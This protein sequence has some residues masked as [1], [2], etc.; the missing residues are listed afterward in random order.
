MFESIV[1]HRW[2]EASFH[3]HGF[4]KNLS[5][6]PYQYKLIRGIDFYEYC[7]NII[8]HQPNV[9]ISFGQVSQMRSNDEGTFLELNGETI[10]AGYIFNSILFK[11]TVVGADEYYLSQHFKGIIIETASPV[12]DPERATLMDFR[13]DQR[14]GT[15]FVYIMPF[16]PKRAL[17][18]YTL[19]SRE[20]LPT[21][22][23]DKGL[24]EYIRDYLKPGSYQITG[25]E[26]GVIPMTNYK[27]PLSDGKIINIGTAGGQTKPSSGYT[28]RFIQKHCAAIVERL[29]NNEHPVV[30]TGKKRFHFYDSVL[31]NILANE[32]V[33]GERVFTMLFKKNKPQDVLRFLDNESKLAEELRIISS[34]PVWPFLKAGIQQL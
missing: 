6:D 17:V 34:L 11:P 14:H 23:Y 27:F 30:A 16:S 4:T 32:K 2:D 21:E 18:E 31:L 29:I 15:A 22:D 19:F 10:Q 20:L 9:D 5:L 28:F 8:Q 33:P 26:F 25:E 12:F 1:Y 13:T 3:N 24:Q 7:F